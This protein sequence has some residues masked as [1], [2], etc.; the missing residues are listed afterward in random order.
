MSDLRRA[1]TIDRDELRLW[2]R[3]VYPMLVGMSPRQVRAN[4][5]KWLAATRYLGPRWILR[6]ADV[7]KRRSVPLLRV[8]G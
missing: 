7:H 6:L 3:E 2:A 5:R 1:K 8:I 4:R